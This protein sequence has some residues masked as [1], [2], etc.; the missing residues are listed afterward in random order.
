M[1]LLLGPVVLG[2]AYYG[3]LP[4]V[5]VVTIIVA[6]ALHEYYSLSRQ[7]GVKPL[8]I[9]GLL[10]SMTILA[11]CYLG[12]WVL[13]VSA[14]AGLVGLACLVH[15][16]RGPQGSTLNLAATAFGPAY[17]ALLLGHLLL[18]RQLPLSLGIP[19]RHAG[20]WIVGL[21]LVVWICDTAAFFLGASV[22][23]HKLA[24]AVSPGKTWEGAAAGLAFGE[25]GALA[26]RPL[27]FPGLGISDA[28]SI[29]A[30]VGVLGQASDLTE[31]LFKRDAGVKDS[32][33]LIPG[34]GG[35]FDRFDSF[36]LAAPAFYWY[37][38]LVAFR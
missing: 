2:S 30:I 24:P 9:L 22:G 16:F 31:S 29:G 13:V 15:V 36:F 11:G 10:S 19:Y 37:L 35:M 4:F 32:S 17:I 25:L 3:R 23:K 21:I 38:K 27:F 14:L 5:A 12:S 8:E 18:V 28:L 20:L 7:L 6:T 34:H 33:N 26:L 1:A